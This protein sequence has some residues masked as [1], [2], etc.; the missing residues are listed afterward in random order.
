[1]TGQLVSTTPQQYLPGEEDVGVDPDVGQPEH[2][3]PLAPFGRWCR[4]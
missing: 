1:M 4:R 3:A 2:R